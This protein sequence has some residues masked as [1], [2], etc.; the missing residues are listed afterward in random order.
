MIPPT[1]DTMN[2]QDKRMPHGEIRGPI[3]EPQIHFVQAYVLNQMSTVA[4]STCS[5]YNSSTSIDDQERKGGVSNTH[6][7]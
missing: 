4:L 2:E 6:G 3:V 1:Y 7:G 5:E